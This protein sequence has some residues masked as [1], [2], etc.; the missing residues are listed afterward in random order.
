MAQIF[1]F[2]FFNHLLCLFFFF[3]Y[4]SWA[5]VKN[6]GI[7]LCHIILSL[8]HSIKTNLNTPSKVHGEP[9]IGWRVRKG[10]LHSFA[11]FPRLPLDGRPSTVCG[12]AA[13][14]VPEAAHSVVH[15]IIRRPAGRSVPERHTCPP[16]L[17]LHARGNKSIPLP[18]CTAAHPCED[19][20]LCCREHM[21]LS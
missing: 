12:S 3:K 19:T 8:M 21:A 20:V 18:Q 11:L 15:P 5:G 7:G 9:K 4:C 1:I 13:L 6:K 2:H 16:P 14:S 10:D 17:C